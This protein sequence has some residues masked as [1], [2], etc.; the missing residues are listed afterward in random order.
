MSPIH[1]CLKFS[2]L[3][4]VF[5]PDRARLDQNYWALLS[6]AFFSPSKWEETTLCELNN[7]PKEFG[8]NTVFIHHCMFH[9]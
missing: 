7:N 9:C 6:A 5:P 1:L 3:T 8:L 4:I 2:A